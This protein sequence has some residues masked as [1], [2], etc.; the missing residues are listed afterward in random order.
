VR[1]FKK[2]YAKTGELGPAEKPDRYGRGHGVARFDFCR[3]ERLC[4]FD[5]KVDFVPGPL[6]PGENRR[7]LRYLTIWS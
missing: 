7:Y 1:I 5:Q 6:A 3:G 2:I 4:L